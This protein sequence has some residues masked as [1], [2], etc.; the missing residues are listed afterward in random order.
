MIASLK[1]KYEA[2]E[3]PLR[4]EEKH[5]MDEQNK[6]LLEVEVFRYLFFAHLQETFGIRPYCNARQSPVRLPFSTKA[7]LGRPQ[8]VTADVN[9]RPVAS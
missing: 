6:S 2:Y 4:L 8:A 7:S 5:K 9:P 3:R 1:R